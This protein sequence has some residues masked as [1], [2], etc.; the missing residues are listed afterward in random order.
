MNFKYTQVPFD[1]HAPKGITYIVS[2]WDEVLWWP[3]Y[4]RH[5]WL[6][7]AVNLPYTQVAW[8]GIL[9]TQAQWVRASYDFGDA[10]SGEILSEVV[11][12]IQRLYLAQKGSL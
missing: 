1:G 7:D 5:R 12:E 6:A 4:T 2:E 11:L 9:D 3:F 8:G 10:P